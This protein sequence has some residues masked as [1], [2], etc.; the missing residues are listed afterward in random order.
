MERNGP[1]LTPS[2]RGLLIGT[3]L[4]SVAP[5]RAMHAAEQFWTARYTAKKGDVS[6]AMYRKRLHPPQAGHTFPVVFL[7]HGSSIPPFPAS[8]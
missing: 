6:L 8:T 3:S 7:V 2:R 1:A 4:A 5:T